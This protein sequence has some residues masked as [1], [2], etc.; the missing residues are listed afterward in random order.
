MLHIFILR[1]MMSESN[2]V[3]IV[4][5]TSGIGLATAKYL[6]NRGYEPIVA[7]R[8]SVNIEGIATFNVDVRSEESVANLFSVFQRKVL[9]ILIK[10]RGIIL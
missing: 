6:K 1:E 7:G 4:G 9:R 2:R 5:G 8:R 10:I 3:I